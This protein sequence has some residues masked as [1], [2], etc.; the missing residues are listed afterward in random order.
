[1]L[2]CLSTRLWELEVC[3]EEYEHHVLKECITTSKGQVLFWTW[4]SRLDGGARFGFEFQLCQ[5]L[6]CDLVT[7]PLYLSFF[8]CNIDRTVYILYGVIM[9]IK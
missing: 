7:K 9:K 8:M 5:L 1:M 3:H 4:D 2:P 6:L